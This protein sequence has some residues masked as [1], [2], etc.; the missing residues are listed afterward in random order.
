MRLADDSAVAPLKD[1]SAFVIYSQFLSGFCEA[2]QKRGS[3]SRAG[4]VISPKWKTGRAH[5]KWLWCF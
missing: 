2:W 4:V 1:N 5:L 3:S